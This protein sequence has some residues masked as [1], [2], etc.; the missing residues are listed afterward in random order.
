V[1]AARVE[2]VPPTLPLPALQ[3]ARRGRENARLVRIG[4]VGNQWK[5]KGGQRLLRWHQEHWRE[6][7][8]LHVASNDVR[9]EKGAVN[10]VWHGSLPHDEVTSMLL[11]MMDLFVLP[12]QNDVFGLAVLEA[13]GA[14]LP[15]VSSRMAAM[16]E[17]VSHGET[18]LLCEWGDEA[19]FVSSI[20]RLLGDPALR[21]RMGHAARRHV[22]ERFD[23]DRW[24]PRLFQLL[25]AVA[26]G[27][28]GDGRD[29]RAGTFSPRSL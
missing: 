10:V 27:C 16:P 11:P 14:A 22:E 13:A 7:A 15:V 4:F 8:E 2:V 28:R 3:P 17:L 21:Q 29:R 5:R 19:C 20:E 26:D 12:T 24:Y 9:P 6:R 1:P 25:A 18:G 23:P